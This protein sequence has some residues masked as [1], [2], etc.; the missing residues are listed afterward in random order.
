V[1]GHG[2]LA[3]AGAALDD[4]HPGEAGADDPVLLALDGGHD[5]AHAAGAAGR[6]GGQQGRL[7]AEPVALGVAQRLQVEDVVLDAQDLPAPGPEMAAAHHPVAVGPGGP[8]ERLGRGGAP[9]DQQRLAVVVEQP[10]AADVQVA[11]VGPVQPPEAQPVLGRGQLGQAASVPGHERVPVHP[12]LDVAAAVVAQRPLQ[13]GL[14]ALAQ[15]VQA[16]VQHR[17]VGLFVF[18]LRGEILHP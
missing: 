15:G 8:V 10:E 3:G 6:E 13:L 18:Q 4:Q 2:R 12:G 16:P 17:D 5:V 9:V 14:G 1:Q 7:A 11:A